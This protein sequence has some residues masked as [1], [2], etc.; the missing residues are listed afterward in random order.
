MVDKKKAESVPEVKIAAELPEL[1]EGGV[2]WPFASPWRNGEREFVLGIITTAAV[3]RGGWQAVDMRTFAQILRESPF[4]IWQQ[5]VINAVWEL[6]GEEYLDVV[7]VEG[8]GDYIVPH[9][10][11]AEVLPQCTLR[12][13]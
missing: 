10:K 9:A 1:P 6:A 13:A 11:L 12:Y 5:G 2:L 3:R 8:Q 7:T 4:A